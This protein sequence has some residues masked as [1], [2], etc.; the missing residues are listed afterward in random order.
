MFFFDT[1][2]GNLYI[3]TGTAWQVAVAALDTSNF[4]EK[5]ADAVEN[6]IAVFD[7]NG[8]VADSGLKVDDSAADDKAIWTA[9]K[10]TE[11]IT[12]AVN[13]MSWQAPVKSVVSELPASPAK[14]DRYLVIAETGDQKD[15]IVEY[16]GT[17][18][19]ATNPVDGMAVFVEDTDQQYAYNG[20]EWANISAGFTYAAGN[21]IELVDNKFSVKAKEKGGIAVTADGVAVDVDAT[22][23]VLNADGKLEVG[24]IDLGEF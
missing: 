11:A 7:A 13:G 6:N 2:E 22:S 24:T 20:T 21:G 1:D 5:V 9:A 23:I 14:G 19:V 17:A 16:N 18:W 10:I 8:A 4:V 12:D 15:K 3:G